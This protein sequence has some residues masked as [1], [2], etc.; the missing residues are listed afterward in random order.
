[1]HSPR[2]RQWAQEPN[3]N[4]QAPC[5]LAPS[6]QAAAFAALARVAPQGT[7]LIGPDT[8]YLYP[9]TWLEAFLPLANASLHAVTHHVYNGASRRTFNS[10]QQLDSPLPEIAWYTA[11]V[12]R[13]APGAQVWAGEDGPIG[14]G[15]DGTCGPNSICG[16]YASSLWYADDMALRA[17]HGFVQYQRQ[18][19]F[20]G[21]YGLL[22][23]RTGAM[24]LGLAEPLLI[25][26][27]FWVNFLWK[28][29]LGAAV[30]NATSSSATVRAYAFS[31][32]P[33]SPYAHPACAAASVQLLLINLS[34]ATSAAVALPPASGLPGFAAF[35]LTPAGG[36]PFAA[37]ASLNGAPL[38]SAI[39]EAEVD[40]ASFLRGIVQA[41]QTGA[42]AGGLA[43]APLSIAFVCYTAAA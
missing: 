15:N 30:L 42:V 22:G 13:L 31:G 41:P 14:G 4:G 36:Q 28:R 20:G 39:D 8:G 9:Q 29:C 43:L 12:R 21:G 25:R 10:P 33:A 19:L 34:N 6:S 11:T 27:D 17:A 24:A 32:A 18:D 37:L 16:T 35:A 40:P 7:R 2:A 23:S 5:N 26:P 3:N 38:P 1:M